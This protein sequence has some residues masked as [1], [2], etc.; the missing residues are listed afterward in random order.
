MI[1]KYL[2]FTHYPYFHSC[3]K[4]FQSTTK[5]ESLCSESYTK[6][7]CDVPVILKGMMDDQRE[8]AYAKFGETY[9]KVLRLLRL[10]VIQKF[11]LS[12]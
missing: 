10:F 9:L 12:D 3:H 7:G 11:L 8:H 4:S 1:L 6:L 2:Y 5:E